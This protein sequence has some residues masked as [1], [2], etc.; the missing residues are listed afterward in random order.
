[1]FQTVVDKSTPTALPPSVGVAFPDRATQATG[2]TAGQTGA[3]GPYRGP[4]LDK[5]AEP[6]R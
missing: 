4:S 1:M 5:G 2:Y 6:E 3:G